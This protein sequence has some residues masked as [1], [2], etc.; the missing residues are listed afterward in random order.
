M[1]FSWYC[2]NAM[3]QI[4]TTFTEKYQE[5]PNYK[6]AVLDPQP[7]DQNVVKGGGCY[8]NGTYLFNTTGTIYQNIYFSS[9]PFIP[10]SFLD[11][12]CFN[13]I[14]ISTALINNL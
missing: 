11:F 5:I 7:Y 9:L 2:F 4:D 1:N 3:E 12:P 10:D 8:G 14:S 6:V 13:Y